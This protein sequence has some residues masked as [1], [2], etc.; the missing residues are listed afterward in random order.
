MGDKF[1]CCC[2]PCCC[3]CIRPE[4]LETLESAND[5]KKELIDI[6]EEDRR[7]APGDNVRI[8]FPFFIF[9]SSSF[10]K[11]W[12]SKLANDTNVP[13]LKIL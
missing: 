13:S 4:G 2:S 8:K 12:S 6:I 1:C 11:K 10:T 3:S 5:K 9:I 7:L